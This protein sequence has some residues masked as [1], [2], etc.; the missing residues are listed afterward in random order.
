ML[1]LIY[2]GSFLF[3]LRSTSWQWRLRKRGCEC[4]IGSPRELGGVELK[5][6]LIAAAAEHLIEADGVRR[7]LAAG[8]YVQRR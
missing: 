7:A 2:H 1:T 3:A 8:R 5:S 4:R 6:P